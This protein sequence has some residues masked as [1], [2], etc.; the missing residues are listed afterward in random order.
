MVVCV[1]Q[2]QI[3]INEI[4]RYNLVGFVGP[5]SNDATIA[6]ARLTSDLDLTLISPSAD[7]TVLSQSKLFPYFLRSTP[8][9]Q[10]DIDIMADILIRLGTKFVAVFYEMVCVLLYICV[11]Y[12][13]YISILLYIVY[14]CK[15]NFMEIIRLSQN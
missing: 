11:M 1:L 10:T 9:M 7:S 3:R 15:L 4:D 14:L 8:S 13:Y 12:I 6:A 2:C 5:T